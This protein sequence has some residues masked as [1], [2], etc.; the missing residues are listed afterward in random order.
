VVTGLRA[1]QS[2]EVF[3]YIDLL[4]TVAYA[5][6]A[7]GILAVKI[8]GDLPQRYE[9]AIAVRRDNPLLR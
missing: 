9:L 7:H 6:Q 3:G 1:V 4:P 8:A 2:G 5:A